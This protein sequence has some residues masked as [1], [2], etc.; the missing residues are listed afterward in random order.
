VTTEFHCPECQSIRTDPSVTCPT[1]GAPPVRDENHRATDEEV[2]SAD[3]EPYITLRYIARLFKVLAVMMVVMLIGE[4][5][6][7]ITAEGPFSLAE[8]IG[9][10]TQL[11][12]LAGLMWG[13]GDLTLLLIDAGHDLRVARILLGRI[14]AETHRRGSLEDQTAKPNTSS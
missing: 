14:N 13:G 7:T 8:L 9:R 4:M 5:Y 3:L 11:L 1:C 10:V 12:V 2:R 6:F